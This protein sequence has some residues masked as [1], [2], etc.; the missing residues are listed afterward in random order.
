MTLK[1]A[2]VIS[3]VLSGREGFA[4]QRET[5]AD[6]TERHGYLLRERI[7]HSGEREG[8]ISDMQHEFPILHVP[9]VRYC[10]RK[11]TL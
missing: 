3:R 10:N 8:L 6:A 4:G 11:R 1:T 2:R 5:T 9:C 7:A